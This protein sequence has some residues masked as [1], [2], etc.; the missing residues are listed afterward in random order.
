MTEILKTEA[1]VLNKIDYSDT[2]KIVNLFTK[3]Y[4]KISVIIKGGRDSKSKIGKISDPLNYL[5]IIYYKKDSRQIQLLTDADL[6]LYF[7]NIKTEIDRLTYATAIL[8][9]FIKLIPENEY[10]LKLFKG[11]IK[12]LGLFDNLNSEPIDLFNSFLM[13]FIK[14]IG[15]EIQLSNCSNCGKSL[16]LNQSFYFN[17]DKG[18]LCTECKANIYSEVY[19]RT[20]LFNYLVSLKSKLKNFDTNI[21]TKEDAIIF[22]EKFL[23]YQFSDFKELQSLKLK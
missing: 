18:I 19:L 4:G 6:I 15:F 17:Y 3:E 5:Q 8:E 11:L 13:F 21:K 2:S 10:N 9:L 23:Q 1:I 16:S 14:E 7:H 12:I 20:E 22:M